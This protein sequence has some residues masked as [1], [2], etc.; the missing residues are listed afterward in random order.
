MSLSEEMMRSVTSQTL[1]PFCIIEMWAEKAG[2]LE[3]TNT[4]LLEAL[5]AISTRVVWTRDLWNVADGMRTIAREAIL[6]VE[7]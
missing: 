5:K 4:D 1:P 3:A 6:K 2:Q 7:E